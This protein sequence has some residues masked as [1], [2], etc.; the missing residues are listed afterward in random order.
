MYLPVPPQLDGATAWREAVRA[1][2]RALGHEAYNVIIDIADPVANATVAHP[3]IAAVD[4]F[5]TSRAK[6]IET[7]ANTIFPASL[8]L[9]HGA[10][11]KR[12]EPG[13]CRHPCLQRAPLPTLQPAT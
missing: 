1:V 7:V 12:P 4:A 9:R 3:G 10:A 11:D 8:Y 5:L 6:P 13:S 2:D